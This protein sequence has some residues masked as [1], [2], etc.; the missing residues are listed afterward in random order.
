[1]PRSHTVPCVCSQQLRNG[2]WLVVFLYL[3]VRN[4]L[5]VCAVM[6]SPLQFLCILLLKEMFVQ[7]QALLYR[8]LGPS[9]SHNI[10]LVA[11]LVLT[12]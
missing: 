6:F 3:T 1:M 8:T 12:M 4:C 11:V 2:S 7:V 9:L 5:S 10:F